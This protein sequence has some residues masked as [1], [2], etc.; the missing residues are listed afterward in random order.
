MGGERE[1]ALDQGPRGVELA[2]VDA[3]ERGLHQRRHVGG[4]LRI[5]GGG[6][7]R[8]AGGLLYAKHERPRHAGGLAGAAPEEEPLY[9]RTGG[10]SVVRSC[11]TYC[12]M[13]PATEAADFSPRSTGVS[14]VARVGCQPGTPPQ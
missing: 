3:L 13:S 10:W 2:R 14:R 6:L 5:E 4:R 9:W 8:H 7:G 12:L 11:S 1:G